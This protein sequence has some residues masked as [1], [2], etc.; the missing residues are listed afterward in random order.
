MGLASKEDLKS[1]QW[2]KKK[3]I[4]HFLPLGF[5]LAL[6]IAL[7]WPYP[8]DKVS[9]WQAGD[10]RIVQ[11]INVC[12]IFVISGLTLK[13]EDIVKAMK[14]P[15]PLLYGCVAILLITPMLAFAATE[16]PFDV[17]AFA[18]GLAIFCLVPT[19]L[20]SGITLVGQAYGNAA[21]ALMLTVATNLLG[22]VT[23]PFLLKVVVSTA[24][25]VD[26]DA[27]GLLINLLLTLLLPL[28]V[29]KLLQDLVPPVKRFV[30]KHKV[31]FGLVNNGSLIIIVWQTLSR[32]QDDIIDTPFGQI[33][34][35]ILAG[36][37][38]HVVYLAGN[39]AIGRLIRLPERE[40]K[41]V[42]IMCSQ[43]TLPVAVAVIG[44][45]DESKVGSQGLLTIPCVIG[46][47]SQLFMD[48]F[49][50]GRMASAEEK[51]MAESSSEDGAGSVDPSEGKDSSSVHK[52]LEP[53][54][55][56]S[57]QEPVVLDMEPQSDTG[58]GMPDGDPAAP[59]NRISWRSN[60][61][62]QSVR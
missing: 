62:A 51:R 30:R 55:R 59:E 42:L 41:A 12:T 18:T 27:V 21:L 4:K 19:T 17:E 52:D 53:P 10:Y 13:T 61:L 22:V 48:A 54:G 35:L 26:L 8:G 39:F 38:V 40:F 45:L 7:A 5:L 36:I 15:L 37:A 28:A 11:T 23:V 20:S 14:A 25:N 6:I 58:A 24:G 56:E 44:F 33:C 34:L 49:I 31:A 57:T 60:Q 43:K 3:L 46:H 50:V 1:W 29:G 16:I 47:I 2:W 32:A 9:S